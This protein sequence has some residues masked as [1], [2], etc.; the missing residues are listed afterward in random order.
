MSEDLH[1]KYRPQKLEQM[2]GQDHIVSSI[3]KL[4]KSGKVPHVFLFEGSSG[5]GKTTTARII[6]RQLGID[7]NNILEMDVATKGGIEDS[8]RLIEG[9][10]YAGFG[11][12]PNKFVILDEVHAA[13]KSFWQ[14][15]LKTLEDTP[16]H[17]YFALCTT[18]SGKVPDTIRTRCHQY[19]IKSLKT[20]DLLELITE[21]AEA[22]EIE[23]DEEGLR[24]IAK[25][26]NGSARMALVNLSKC[27]GC[28][29]I[30]EIKATLESVDGEE[31]V[32]T[33]CRK[34]VG[35]E[36]F[37]IVEAIA[38]VSK[39]KEKNAE[40]IRIVLMNYIAAVVMKSKK[41]SE[42]GRL[43]QI[44][45]CFSTPYNSSE[46]MAP[47]LLSLGSALIESDL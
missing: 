34:M 4:F 10:K 22:E 27:R 19:T 9:L 29:S 25:E 35:R 45:D 37:G 6:A 31:E 44:M 36:P 47:L 8:R 2:I 30:K 41:E 16:E 17:V 26:S 3:G 7:E 23:L 24:L 12:N 39:L 38:L 11:K 15:L 42:I 18:E 1:R 43:L 40:S 5:C 33:L 28:E 20:S 21:V 13:S 14:S 32:I 46:K